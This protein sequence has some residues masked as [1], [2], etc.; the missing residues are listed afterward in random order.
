MPDQA[1][2]KYQ[3]VTNLKTATAVGLTVAFPL[4]RAEE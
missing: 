1:P 2:K 3:L 4:V